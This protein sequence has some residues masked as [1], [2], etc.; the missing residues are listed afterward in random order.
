MTIARVFIAAALLITLAACQPEP[1][2]PPAE[3]AASPAP[4]P[5]QIGSVRNLSVAGDIY[6]A[7]QPAKDDFQLLKDRGVKTI[8]NLRLP[9]E[10]DLDERGIVETLGMTYAALPWNGPDQLTDDRLDQMRRLLRDSERPV[11]LHCA[12]ANRV[13][14]GW[15]AYRVLDEGVDIEQAVAEAKAAGMRTPAYETKTRDYIE[16]QHKP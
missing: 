16:R 5:A 12:S 4:Q 2:S 13:G 11:V 1:T 10:S 6:L 14:A 3:P 15:V 8:I 9:Q 7:G